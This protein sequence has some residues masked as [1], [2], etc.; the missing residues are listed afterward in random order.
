MSYVAFVADD[1]T[2]ASDVLAQA[3]R[4]GLDAVLVVGEGYG[5]LPADADVVGIAGPSR[6]LGG[7]AFDELVRAQLCRAATLDADVLLY[8]V[9][10]TFDSSPARGNIGRAIELLQERLPA[11]GPIAVAPAQPDFGRYT[12]FSNHFAVYDGHVHRLD[13]HPVMSRHPSTPMHEADLRQVLAEQFTQYAEVGAIHLPSYGDNTFA[14]RWSACRAGADAAFVVDAV[15]DHHLD[16][17]ARALLDDHATPAAVVGSGGIMAALARVS[18]GDPVREPEEQ[19]ASGPVLTVSASASSTTAAQIADALEQGWAEIPL[20][21]ELLSGTNAEL[22]A[23][24]EQQTTAQLAEG[25]SVV[26]HTTRGADDPRYEATGSVDAAHLGAILGALAATMARQGL[27]RDIAVLGGDTSSH[28][29]AAMGI[30]ELRVLSQFVTAGPVCHSDDDA[31]VAGCR[32]L[33]KGGQVGPIDVLRRFAGHSTSH[34][35]GE[36]S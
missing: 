28:A 1:L 31:A 17:L 19:Q 20:P 36:K 33:L 29:L 32:L 27:T 22:L 12:A 23:G 8:K 30:R 10:S 15:E 21:A 5:P 6:S 24:I 18:T 9:C 4:Y 3:H 14:S 2:G 34:Q 25:R 26:I 7:H 11:H 35:Q 16:R 13:V